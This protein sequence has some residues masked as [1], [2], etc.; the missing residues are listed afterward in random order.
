[1]LV[2]FTVELFHNNHLPLSVQEGLGGQFLVQNRKPNNQQDVIT[3]IVVN[4]P[5]NTP[6][7]H[8][9]TLSWQSPSQ[10]LHMFLWETI[11]VPIWLKHGA[12]YE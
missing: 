4:I 2:R 9:L 5:S 10:K 11:Y 8:T 12:G 3:A 7:T 6:A 1:M